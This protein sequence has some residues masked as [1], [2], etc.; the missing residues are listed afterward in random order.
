MHEDFCWELLTVK[1][2][3]IQIPIL[4][5]LILTFI[6]GLSFLSLN[7]TASSEENN[8]KTRKM[9]IALV[10]EDEGASFDDKTLD[11]GKAFVNSLNDYDNH[12]WFV[13]SRGTAESGLEDN[14]YDLMIIIPQEFTQKALSIHSKNPEQVVLNYRINS[15][16]DETVRAQAEET[17]SDILNDFNRRIIDVYFASILGNLQEAQ[18]HVTQLVSDYENLAYTYQQQVN[19]PLSGYTNR[20]GQIQQN[21]EFSKASFSSFEDTLNTYEDLL[22]NQFDYF[23][24]YQ[25]TIVQ[26]QEVQENNQ[27]IDELFDQELK[28]L[29]NTLVNEDVNKNLQALRDANS[30]INAQLVVQKAK[31]ENTQEKNIADFANLIRNR[32]EAKRIE[33][34]ENEFDPD[35]TTQKIVTELNSAITGAFDNNDDLSILLK[36]QQ[37]MIEAKIDEQIK[38]LPKIDLDSLEATNLSTELKTEIKNV[39]LITDKY[40]EEFAKDISSENNNGTLPT[41]I[42]RLKKKLNEDGVTLRDTVVLPDSEEALRELRVYGISEGFQI[43]TLTVIPPTEDP[44]TCKNYSES[45]PCILPAS[46]HGEFTIELALKLKDDYLNESIHIH[47]LKQF[48]W[49][50]YQIDKEDQESL[51]SRDSNN[52]DTK[53]GSNVKGLTVVQSKTSEEQETKISNENQTSTNESTDEQATDQASKQDSSGVGTGTSNQDTNTTKQ[54]QTSDQ[55]TTA[56]AEEAES[57][58]QSSTSSSENVDKT[59]TKNQNDNNVNNNTVNTPT[60]SNPDENKT[61][62]NNIEH[63][64]YHHTVTNP[65]IEDEE[66]QTILASIENT[67]APYQQL[68]SSYEM[69]FGFP[70][71]CYDAD[72]NKRCTIIDESATIL[73]SSSADE[74]KF[75]NKTDEG[76]VTEDSLYAMFNKNVAELLT[77]YISDQ[78]IKDIENK[79]NEPLVEYRGLIENYQLFIDETY[80]EAEKLAE[81]IL[82]TKERATALED[83]LNTLFE[84][85]DSWKQRSNQL[86]DNQS[87]VLQANNE[88]QQMVV[89]LDD[90]FQPLFSQ[91]QTLADQASTNLNEAE[92]VYQTLDQVDEQANDVQQSGL[93]LVRQADQLANDLSTQ[94]I[95]DQKFTE[96]FS[97]V[98]ANSRI[99]ERQNEELYDFLSSPVEKKNDGVILG[100]NTTVFSPNVIILIAF[101]VALFTGYGISSMNHGRSDLNEFKEETLVGGNLRI[102][103]ITTGI[104][105]FEGILLGII[106]GYLLGVDGKQLLIWTGMMFIIMLAMGLTATYLLRQ[107]KLIG[108]FIL[109]SIVSLY[110][111]LNDSIDSSTSK[112]SGLK[113][114]SPLHY[115]E[116]VLNGIVLENTSYGLIAL[117]LI[118][119]AVVT[120]VGNL[121]V[122]HQKQA[123]K[124]DEE[125]VA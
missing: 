97:Q 86:V 71:S 33:L 122:Y 21:T 99:G 64:Y 24:D 120:F 112:Y 7:H 111:M 56:P 27:T 124:K 115:V 9:S 42:N 47:D 25:S 11:F 123:A 36:G 93:N 41:E 106:S 114:F 100:T 110:L 91:S 15:T 68:L 23:N 88:E 53:Q 43:D 74:E 79:I 20:F 3:F 57:S 75:I 96:N 73:G 101:F 38:N 119:L 98:M 102:T 29:Q 2:S 92:T 12:D 118:L 8:E 49:D 63:H 84:N 28:E 1:K 22:V 10:N 94:L 83:Q 121:F 14:T 40:K 103:A 51:D 107:L 117:G 105:A 109:L 55:E 54:D 104:S 50:L 65:V 82:Q 72:S 67:I 90:G 76:L 61:E 80:A 70:L 85:V 4:L 45:E 77:D 125:D 46:D 19:Q 89:S 44:I 34:E 39:S 32:L 87:R 60:T 17:A 30:Y 95:N 69:Y 59:T 5:A 108:M 116:K 66:I 16:D 26:V 113:E 48:K 18:D 35:E 62:L 78:V 52:D 13:V 37:D 58:Q 6:I 81:K 31:T